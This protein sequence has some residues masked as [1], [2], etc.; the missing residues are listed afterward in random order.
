M[1]FLSI[2]SNLQPLKSTRLILAVIDYKELPEDGTAFEQFVREICLIYGLHPQ[3]SGKGPDQGRDLLIEEKVQGPLRPFT[4]KWL[5]QCKHNAHSNRSVG[6]DDVG[7]I[8][9]DCRQVGAKGYLLACSTQPTSSLVTKLQE[10]ESVDSNGL[11]TAVWDGVDLEKL[12]HEPRCFALGH[13]FFPE[14]Y[15]ST[16]WK[17]YNKGA[18][19]KWTAHYKSY[20]IHLASRIAGAYPN[21]LE[22]EYIISVIEQINP[23]KEEAI[24]PRSIYFDD[25]HEQFVVCLD[26]LVPEGSEPSLTPRDFNEVMNDGDGLHTTSDGG[27]YYISHWDVQMKYIKPSSDHFHLDHYNHY[28]PTEGTYA[29]GGIRN[30]CL[31]DLVSFNN[32]WR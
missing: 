8:V 29:I 19:N 2:E 32:E 23:R 6:R 20:F 3:W 13:I 15:A 14:S 5:V 12:L 26:Y 1:L 25:K 31:S 16:K 17:L 7:S 27:H 28:N 9:D 24:R 18:P 21:L 11:V 22:C 4:R 10:I 30:Y